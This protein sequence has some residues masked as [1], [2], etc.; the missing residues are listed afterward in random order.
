MG[1][2]DLNTTK[3]IF[4]V[5]LIC[6]GFL[7]ILALPAMEDLPDVEIIPSIDTSI[8]TEELKQ[9]RFIFT[10]A[11]TT[12]YST[13]GTSTLST[14]PSCYSTQA[15]IATCSSTVLSG[16]KKRESTLTEDQKP[17][18]D[19]NGEMVDFRDLI[20]ASRASRHNHEVTHVKQN[21]FPDIFE[22]SIEDVPQCLQGAL[23]DRQGRLVTVTSTATSFTYATATVTVAATQSLVFSSAAAFC[24]PSQLVS[25]ASISAC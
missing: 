19:R 22:A 25:S 24:F 7:A 8:S 3:M 2:L 17:M 5:L 13:I 11:Y 10:Q 4:Q 1:S 6:H 20:K 16:R 15:N 14:Y 12:I 23:K 18:V 9:P 21:N